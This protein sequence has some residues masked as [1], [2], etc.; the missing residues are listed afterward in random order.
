[1]AKEDDLAEEVR[2]HD[3]VRLE[4]EEADR[5]RKRQQEPETPRADPQEQQEVGSTELEAQ[6]LDEA[7]A[8][9][10]EEKPGRKKRKE[11]KNQAVLEETEETTKGK[12][13]LESEEGKEEEPKP[14]KVHLK[15]AGPAEL[16]AEDLDEALADVSEEKQRRKKLIDSFTTLK[17]R[18]SGKRPAREQRRG[19][20]GP[21]FGMFWDPKF[22]C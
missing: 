3:R 14:P 4:I 18:E 17:A 7:L 15:E 16:E 11:R 2:V 22:A 10:Q 19:R 13:E 9:V 20:R 5:E 21:S 8:D 6:D 12:E 1:M